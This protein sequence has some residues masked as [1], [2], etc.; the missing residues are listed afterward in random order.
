MTAL[1]STLKDLPIISMS[2]SKKSDYDKL[3]VRKKSLLL[4]AHAITEHQKEKNIILSHGG[5]LLF[6]KVY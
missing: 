4:N 6:K 5:T 2:T 1:L 3:I